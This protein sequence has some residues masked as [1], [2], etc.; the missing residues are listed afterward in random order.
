VQRRQACRQH[1]CDAGRTFWDT[2]GWKLTATDDAGLTLF[3]LQFIGYDAP[4]VQGKSEAA[5]G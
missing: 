1:I 3:V 4:S 2:D 5:A